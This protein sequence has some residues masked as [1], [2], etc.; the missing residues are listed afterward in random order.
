MISCWLTEKYLSVFGISP[1]MGNEVQGLSK[2][3]KISNLVHPSA[4]LV[5]WRSKP[6]A[7]LSLQGAQRK[8]WQAL[9]YNALI[10][11]FKV[12]SF[13]TSRLGSI[14][15]GI[16]FYHGLSYTLTAI[17]CYQQYQRQMCLI[18]KLSHMIKQMFAQTKDSELWTICK[19]LHLYFWYACQY[20][21]NGVDPGK[22][23]A[24]IQ[25]AN[26]RIYP[27]CFTLNL[28]PFPACMW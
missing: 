14:Q 19:P 25:A 20:I 11:P 15:L 3:T 2:D 17:G 6:H 16:W 13:Q 1:S 7:Q 22:V 9:L 21:G 5:R 10:L 26:P 28:H 4:N 23:N 24:Q 8:E 12:L 18:L 27:A